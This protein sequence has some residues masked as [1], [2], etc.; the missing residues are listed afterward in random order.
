MTMKNLI[1]SRRSFIAG[2]TAT[3]GVL[4]APGLLRAQ[5]PQ[6]RHQ[7]LGWALAGGGQ[8]EPV[9]PLHR[10]H[11]GENRN[12]LARVLCQAGAAGEDRGL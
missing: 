7:L 8:G 12:C 1:T 2:A 5:T 9:R 6:H 11:R 4:A 10:R 3:A